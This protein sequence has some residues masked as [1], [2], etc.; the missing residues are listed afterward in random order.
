METS[1]VDVLST[2]G[3]RQCREGHVQVGGEPGCQRK[4]GDVGGQDDSDTLNHFM[5]T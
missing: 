4:K 5:W 1:A 2:V 3:R